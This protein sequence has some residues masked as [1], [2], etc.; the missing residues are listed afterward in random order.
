MMTVWMVSAV[1]VMSAAEWV[2]EV[3]PEEGR[4]AIGERFPNG[5]KQVTLSFDREVTVNPDC[6]KGVAMFVGNTDDEGWGEPSEVVTADAVEVDRLTG[7]MAAIVFRGNYLDVGKYRVE[8]PAGL[9]R[10][11]NGELSEAVTLNYEIYREWSI[12]PRD[13]T[14]HGSVSLWTLTAD[15]ADKVEW[16]D[17][18]NKSRIELI[19]GQRVRNLKCASVRGNVIEIEACDELRRPVTIEQSGNYVLV[20]PRGILRYTFYGTDYPADLTDYSIGTNVDDIRVHFTVTPMSKPAV[21]PSEGELTELG[22]FIL[23]F[24]ADCSLISADTTLESM[25]FLREG[26]ITTETAYLRYCVPEDGVSVQKGTV[27]LTPVREE[28]MSDEDLREPLPGEYTLRLSRQLILVK[29]LDEKIYNAPYEYMFEVKPRPFDYSVQPPSGSELQQ[30]SEIILTFGAPVA[31]A[32]GVGS[33][34]LS[35][36]SGEITDMEVTACIERGYGDDL[37][38][39]DEGMQCRLTLSRPLVEKDVYTLTLPA[40]MFVRRGNASPAIRVVY[41][42]DGSLDVKETPNEDL[43][44]IYSPDGTEIMRGAGKC[45]LRR[46]PA[47]IYVI[48]GKTTVIAGS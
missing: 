31:M 34:C 30:L 5:L 24:P 17:N 48:N 4:L 27:R 43:Y 12:E 20:I 8:I 14:V 16:T 39:A 26:D 29:Y 47:G 42:V 6:A 45:E 9:W 32:E 13:H 36:E 10:D 44:D 18:A 7:R 38:A 21:S 46:L 2:T 11:S 28:G 15:V 25:L 41:K 40:G 37:A 23:T 1:A 3:L 33:G 19:T 35:G 22:D